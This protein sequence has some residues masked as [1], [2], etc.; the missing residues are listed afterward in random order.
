MGEGSMNCPGWVDSMGCKTGDSCV[1]YGDECPHHC[2]FNPPADCGDGMF[3][4]AGP[5]DYMG[6][7]SA[8]TCVA[9]GEEC[10]FYCPN[11][12]PTERNDELHGSIRCQRLHA[13]RHLC[14]SGRGVP[15]LLPIDAPDGLRRRINELPRMGRLH[16]LQN[17]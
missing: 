9:N 2:P 10:P 8:D 6:C 4:C 16:G 15:L 7:A 5:M 17:R 13:S 12:P 11:T 1:P 3:P 14:S